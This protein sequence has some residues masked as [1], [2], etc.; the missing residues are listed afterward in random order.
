MTFEALSCRANFSNC[1]M[2][3]SSVLRK[4]ISSSKMIAATFSG[5]M[6]VPGLPLRVGNASPRSSTTTGVSPLKKPGS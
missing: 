2:P 1:A 3:R 6:P 4:E 5:V